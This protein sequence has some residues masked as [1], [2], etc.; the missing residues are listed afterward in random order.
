[1]TDSMTGLEKIIHKIQQDCAGECEKILEEARQQAEAFLA[2]AREQAEQDRQQALAAAR[3]EEETQ[4]QLALSK[5]EHQ[6]KQTLLAAKARLIDETL[7]AALAALKQLPDD[8]YLE[9]IRRL[10]VKHAR[11]GHGVLR[12]SKQ[13]LARLPEGFEAE[14]NQQLQGQGR[15]VS[16]DPEPMDIDGGFVIQYQGMEQNC[17]FE[18][19]MGALRDPLRD[20]LHRLMFTRDSE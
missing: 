9:L 12:F 15:T 20:E 6:R 18:A 4:R 7:D 5:A 1:M 3:Q 17:R 2:A 19:L 14:M 13:D 10:I 8:R 16:V 11:P